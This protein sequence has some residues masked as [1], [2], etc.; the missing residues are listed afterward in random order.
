[1]RQCWYGGRGRGCCG[2]CV[3]GIHGSGVVSSA[4][5]VLEMSGGGRCVGGVCEMCLAC[6]WVGGV[7]VR[8]LGLPIL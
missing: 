1:M 8:G 4:D 6:G 2:E 5:D 7:G 3:G